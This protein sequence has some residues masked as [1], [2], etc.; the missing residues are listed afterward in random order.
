MAVE[1][2]DRIACRIVEETRMARLASHPRARIAHYMMA[3]AY[4]T[5]VSRMLG[6]REIQSAAP[7]ACAAASRYAGLAGSRSEQTGFLADRNA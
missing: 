7:A 3:D 6:D 2:V 4:R 5:M 1:L